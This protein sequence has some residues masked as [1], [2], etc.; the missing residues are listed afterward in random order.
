MHTANG[1]NNAVNRKIITLFLNNSAVN[2]K[3][4][5]EKKIS[6]AQIKKSSKN[7]TFFL[8]VYPSVYWGFKKKFIFFLNFIYFFYTFFVITI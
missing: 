4:I 5:T 6:C 8:I 7:V 2:K 3:I 1:N